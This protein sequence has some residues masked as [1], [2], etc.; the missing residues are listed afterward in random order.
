MNEKSPI[1]KNAAQKQA[2]LLIQALAS[3]GNAGRYWLNPSGKTLPRFYPKGVS[4]SPFNAL[5]MA[6]DSDAKGCK[7]NLYTLFAEAKRRG[8]PVREHEKGAPFLFYN[9][10]K[11]VNCTN[12]EDV[13]DRKA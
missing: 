2:G 8:E 5:V 7:T 6:L 3:A 12:T 11:Y 4:V 9:W 10:N 1:E 13:I